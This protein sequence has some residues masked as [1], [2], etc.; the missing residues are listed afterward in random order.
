MP[1]LRRLTP[2]IIVAAISLSAF[3]V[4]ANSV[5]SPSIQR[6]NSEGVNLQPS[7]E[8]MF[9]LGQAEF[10]F[11]PPD[12]VLATVGDTL[13]MLDSKNQVIWKETVGDVVGQPFVMPEG[14]IHVMTVQD[15]LHLVLD[16]KTGK[17][18]KCID[19]HTTARSNF[20]QMLPYTQNQYLVVESSALL[21][22]NKEP[23]NRPDTLTLWQGE[24]VIWS[25]SIPPD[26]QIRVAGD[27]ILAIE[28][29]LAGI[30]LREV[31]V[32]KK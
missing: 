32:P 23:V 3:I 20:I 31:I 18:L 1:T 11:V 21:P 30:I 4:L 10:T 16:G 7:D 22:R 5:T 19:C 9:A 28:K 29:H 24:R 15:K 25:T 27:K 14:L 8:S 13:Y 17:T 2:I 26:A 12:R 6:I